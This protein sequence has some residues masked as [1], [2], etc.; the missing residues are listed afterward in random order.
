MSTAPRITAVEVWQVSGPPPHRDGS[1]LQSQ[2]KMLHVYPEFRDGPAAGAPGPQRALYLRIGT[3]TGVEGWYGPIDPEAAVAL[4][5]QLAGFLVGRDA[6]A[7]ATLTDQMARLDRHARHGHLRMAISAADNALWDLRGRYFDVPVYRLLGGP[8]RDRLP[9]YASTLG[10][11]LD[12]SEATAFARSLAAQ[13]YERQKWFLAHG[14][15]S[16]LSGM[17]TNVALVAALSETLGTAG[18]LMLDVFMGWDLNYARDITA[19][20]EQYRPAWLEEPFPPAQYPA[21][22]ELRRSTRIPLAAGEHLYD[23]AEALPYLRDGAV[24]VLQTDP[25]WCGGVTELTRICALAETFGVPVIPHGHGLHAAIHVI[26]SQSPAVC[27]LVEYLL[28]TM[29][30]R[31]HFERTPPTPVDGHFPLPTG[32]GFGIELDDTTIEHR[33]L[34]PDAALQ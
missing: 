6:L 16:G 14:P 33:T 32:P 25:E 1:P 22:G 13:G 11:S 5:R 8:T 29:P 19:R 23:R 27:P 24:S 9:A 21:L 3:D 17:D 4:H 30:T 2:V 18:R 10:S 28:H 20:I 26:A 34:W 7:G 31:H 12:P 15:G